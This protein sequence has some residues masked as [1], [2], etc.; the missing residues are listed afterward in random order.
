MNIPSLLGLP[1][2]FLELRRATS[3]VAATSRG[4]FAACLSRRGAR[5]LLLRSSPIL[6][7]LWFF[8]PRYGDLVEARAWEFRLAAPDNYCVVVL[9]LVL[10]LF[11]GRSDREEEDARGTD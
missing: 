11:L 9:F 6:L 1:P 7:W 8:T 3:S 4:C 2:L 5:S 10:V